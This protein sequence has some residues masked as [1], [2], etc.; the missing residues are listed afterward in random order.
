MKDLLA[1]NAPALAALGALI[2]VTLGCFGT[3]SVSDWESQLAG[4]KLAMAKN[5]GALSDSMQIWFC[6]SGKFL[7]KKQSSGFSGGGSGTLSTAGEEVE[8]GRWSVNSSKLVLQDEKGEK[9]EL[10]LA[11]GG[12]S[13]VIKLNGTGFLVTSHSSDCSRD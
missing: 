3:G 12:D 9:L 1:R 10:E 2:I 7:A 13:N 6:S 8:V 5:S 11:T 4:K